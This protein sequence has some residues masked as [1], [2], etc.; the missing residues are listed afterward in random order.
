MSRTV[1]NYPRGFMR[2]P[3]GAKQAK[4]QEGTRARAIPPSAW[5]DIPPGKEAFIPDKIAVSL[6]EKGLNKD[7]VIRRVQKRTGLE[8]SAARNIVHHAMLRLKHKRL[9]GGR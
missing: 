2:S 6:L 5:E 9:F 4:A 3:R 1:R 8:T 7:E